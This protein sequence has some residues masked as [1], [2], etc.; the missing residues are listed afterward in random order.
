MTTKEEKIILDVRY[1]YAPSQHIFCE[2]VVLKV[3]K[4][5]NFFG[6]ICNKKIVID[7]YKYADFD[8]ALTQL[9]EIIKRFK[10]YKKIEVKIDTRL[11]NND[12]E[13]YLF[14]KKGNLNA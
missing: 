4:E 14:Y 7:E 6:F 8:Y 3:I 11:D 1:R 2:V 13:D 5:R 10:K 9:E 12:F